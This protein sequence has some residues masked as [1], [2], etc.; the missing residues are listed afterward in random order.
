MAMNNETEKT[1]DDVEHGA[2][3]NLGEDSAPLTT[4]QWNALKEKAAKSDDYWDRLLRQTADFENFKKRAARERQ[5][6]TKYANESLLEK[7]IPVIDNFEAALAAAENSSAGD[8]LKTGVKM[9]HAQ[10]KSVLTEAGLQEIDASQQKF[11]PNLHE[12]VSQKETDEMPDGQV[13]QQLRKGYKFRERLVRPATVIVAHKPN[14][15]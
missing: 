15:A 7:L 2:T 9:I 11:D 8:S 4:E 10:L 5:E 3:D 13:F 6:A 12:A 14:A 1:N